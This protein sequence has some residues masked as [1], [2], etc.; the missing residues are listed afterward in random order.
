MNFFELRLN[1]MEIIKQPFRSRAHVVT[2]IGLFAD[3]ALSLFQ[4]E[5]IDV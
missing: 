4:H 3:V 5:D 2:R 1:Q